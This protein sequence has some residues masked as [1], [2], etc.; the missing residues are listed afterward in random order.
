MKPK[1]EKHQNTCRIMI[2]MHE[3]SYHS[4]PESYSDEPQSYFMDTKEFHTPEGENFCTVET[5]YMYIPLWKEFFGGIIFV[6]GQSWEELVSRCFDY[7]S[8]QDSWI[9]YTANE[10]L[11]VLRRYGRAFEEDYKKKYPQ[12]ARNREA[13]DAYAE[14]HYIWL[15]IDLTSLGDNK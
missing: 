10:I 13:W 7:L 14:N 2:S 5:L 6:Y 8:S 9:Q 4:E 1:N 11:N 3:H 12:E 15:K